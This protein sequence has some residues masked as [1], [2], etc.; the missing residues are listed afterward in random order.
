M[1]P[2]HIQET[3]PGVH[4]LNGLQLL[5]PEQSLEPD[6]FELR[7]Q[8]LMLL[9]GYTHRQL[10]MAYRRGAANPLTSV[11]VFA[12]HTPPDRRLWTRANSPEFRSASKESKPQL[13]ALWLRRGTVHPP[14][15]RLA[16]IWGHW[17]D[18]TPDD[19]VE[20]RSQWKLARFNFSDTLAEYSLLAFSQ[21]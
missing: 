19:W 11:E 17:D 13:H 9:L 15:T 18:T 4:P 20:L 14:I 1:N 5:Q 2:F 7:R 12:S 10:K 16:L 21:R 6:W 3:Q 8:P